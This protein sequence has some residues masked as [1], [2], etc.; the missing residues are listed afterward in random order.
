MIVSGPYGPM[1]IIGIGTSASRAAAKNEIRPFAVTPGFLAVIE[2]PRK[3]GGCPGVVLA[4]WWCKKN[5]YIYQIFHG[6][7]MV[8]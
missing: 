7:L 1:V 2:T 5:I 8:I 6:D 4:A 3:R